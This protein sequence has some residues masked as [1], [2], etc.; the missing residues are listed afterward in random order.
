MQKISVAMTTYNGEG[1]LARQLNS[2]LSQ[3][4]Q[5]D[6]LVVCDDVSTDGTIGVLND[7]SIKAPFPV[8]IVQNQK[9]LG[10]IK[11]FE[12][13]M[14]LCSGDIIV[15]CDQDDVWLPDKI[16]TLESIFNGTDNCGMAF[17][18][19]Q[20]ID[21]SGQQLSFLLWESVGFTKKMQKLT[22]RGK[23]YQVFSGTNYVTGATAAVTK[24]FYESTV[25]FPETEGFLHDLWLATVAAIQNK[26]YFSEESTIQYRKH[27][28]QQIGCFAPISV[29]MKNFFS[30]GNYFAILQEISV[31]FEALNERQLLTT[32]Q[33]NYLKKKIQYFTFRK[34][35]PRNRL[36]RLYKIC[37]HLLNGDYHLF[38]SGIYSAAK[39]FLKRTIE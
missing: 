19:A 30:T 16:K 32:K 35:L 27:M 31:I 9:N 5:I 8:I 14:G 21:E 17:T 11:N 34:D 3:S 26:L 29:S 15:L 6:E 18:N 39:D 33:S 4:R 2:M 7:F 22:K 24:A 36:K 20:V 37:W 12:K 23:G 38:G 1:F 10:C 28:S 25:P 13:S